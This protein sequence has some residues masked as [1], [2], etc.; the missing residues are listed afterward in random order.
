MPSTSR[1]PAVVGAFLFAT[2]GMAN[3]QSLTGEF[4]GAGGHETSGTAVIEGRT[5]SLADDFTFD[6]APDPKLAFGNSETADE[7]TIF[8]PL[9]S[10]TG[11]QSYQLPANIQPADH[12]HLYLW[13]EQ[14]S[15][16][17]GR[18][19]LSSQ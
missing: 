19:R 4:V 11:Q 15:V 1:F 9:R 6:G 3:A 16:P 5:V 13:C 8:S 2:M 17:L 12:T 14:Y 18:A 10:N 7:A